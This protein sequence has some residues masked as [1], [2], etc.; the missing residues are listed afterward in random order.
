[1]TKIIINRCFGGFGVSDEAV[2]RYGEIKGWR[3]R[4]HLESGYHTA[5]YPIGYSGLVSLLIDL[6]DKEDIKY[7]KKIIK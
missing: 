4:F 7:R 2:K 5:L 6:G 1:M 3:E